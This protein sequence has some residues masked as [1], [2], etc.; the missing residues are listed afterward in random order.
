MWAGVLNFQARKLD[1]SISQLLL[2]PFS[3]QFQ[4][5]HSRPGYF[6]I[7]LKVRQHKAWGFK[8]QVEMVYEIS[9]PTARF[10]YFLPFPGLE[11][12]GFVLLDLQPN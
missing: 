11:A 2:L 5:S 6:L 12:L 4:L 7:G 8:P 1:L 3:L 9:G 10:V